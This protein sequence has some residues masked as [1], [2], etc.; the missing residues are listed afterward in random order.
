[1]ALVLVIVV[2]CKRFYNVTVYRV[3]MLY[4]SGLL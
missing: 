3:F 2:A 4:F 1:M